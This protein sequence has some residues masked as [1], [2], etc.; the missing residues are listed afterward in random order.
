[1]IK[2]YKNK[3]SG[4]MVM[5]L[6]QIWKSRSLIRT[7]AIN[8][9]VIR[10]KG[11]MLGALWSFLEP[12]LMLGILYLIFSNVF[13]SN[14]EHYPLYLLLGIIM[15]NY[16][17]RS[18]STGLGIILARTGI[19]NQTYFPRAILPIS[20]C[21]TMFIMLG[22]E[23]V[24]FFGFI[25]GFQFLPPLTILIL[26]ILVVLLFCLTLGISFILSVMYIRFRDVQ[27]IWA[28]VTYAGFFL[29]PVIYDMS[30]FPD[31]IAQILLL[32]PMAQFL[33]IAHNAALYGG[34]PSVFA[35]TYT[36]VFSVG[37]LIVGYIIF[38]RYEFKVVEEL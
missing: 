27:N 22:V 31:N 4:S 28:I 13:K 15:W 20:S 23:F 19:V 1:M 11:S 32:N 10:Y 9:L 5:H 30:I 25:A 35:I 6:G 18:T 29:T 26:P 8:D 16:F 24:V 2:H 34:L 21:I 37:I 36:A 38:K 3:K 17:A 12:M 7:F 33:E 14:I